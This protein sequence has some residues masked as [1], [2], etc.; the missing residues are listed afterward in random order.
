MPGLTAPVDIDAPIYLGSNFVWGEA[1]RGGR[2]LPVQTKFERIIVPSAHI[3]RNIITMAKELDKVRA[4]CGG[5]PITVTSWYRDPI[6]NRRVGG[7]SNSQH[8]L[9]WGVDIVIDGI[10]PITTYETLDKWWPG[11]LGRNRYYTHLDLRHN[12]GWILARWDYGQS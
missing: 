8:L 7:V 12:M 10:D 4:M 6:S 5:R 11:G 2:R 9:G 1:T 3:T